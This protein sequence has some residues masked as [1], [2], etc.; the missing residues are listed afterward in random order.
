MALVLPSIYA[1]TCGCGCEAYEFY[2]ADKMPLVVSWA[3]LALANSVSPGVLECS[4]GRAPT[5]G[6][7]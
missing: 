4:H 7:G 5:D 2:F 6:L 3:L 1:T